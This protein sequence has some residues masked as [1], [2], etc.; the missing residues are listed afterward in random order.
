MAIRSL[1]QREPVTVSPQATVMEAVKAM[2]TN[3]IGAVAVAE[4][5]QL[6]GIFTER[7]VVKKIVLAGLDANKTPISQVMT[8][9][10]E[11]APGS[12]SIHDALEIMRDH[13]FRHLPIT[14]SK[15]KLEGVV[16]LRHILYE[17]MDDLEKQAASLENY[18]SSD[19]PG[20]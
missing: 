16:S 6:K 14:D 8:S 17:I 15:G 18:M 5:G 4:Q 9:P 20:G 3:K 2:V 11:Q 1:V 13:Q 10:V 19:G 7:D 12:T